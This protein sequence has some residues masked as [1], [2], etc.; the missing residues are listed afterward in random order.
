MMAKG[1][2]TNTTKNKLARL[3]RLLDIYGAN[4]DRWPSS[5]RAELEPFI[6][7]E[8]RAQRMIRESEALEKLINLSSPLAANEALKARIVA[9]AAHDTQRAA[10]VVPISSA[11]QSHPRTGDANSRIRAFWPA[12]ALAASFAVGLYLGAAGLGTPAFENA[13]E[14]T[15]FVGGSADDDNSFWPDLRAGSPTE[16]IL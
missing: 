3:E 11:G 9:S 7:I 13:F 16:G 15:E 2:M 5:E 12:A 10:R 4:P 6:E 1:T 8:A 14:V